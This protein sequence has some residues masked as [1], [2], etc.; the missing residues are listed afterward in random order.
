MDSIYYRVNPKKK[1][2]QF[3]NSSLAK[4]K[5]ILFYE[6]S[7]KNEKPI[8]EHILKIFKTL[9]KDSQYKSKDKIHLIHALTEEY[10]KLNNIQLE[11]YDKISLNICQ[12]ISKKEFKM[13][14]DFTSE[15]I[16]DICILI[17]LGYTKLFSSKKKFKTYEKFIS[18]IEGYRSIFIDLIK[19]Y[20]T[21]NFSV[22]SNVPEIPKNTI[23]N[24]ILLLMEILQGIK[25]INFNLVEYNKESIL[26]YIII[27]LNSDWLFPFV[28]EID[29]DLSNDN[30]SKVIERLYYQKEKNIYVKAK[31]NFCSDD[32]DEENDKELNDIKNINL[33]KKYFNIYLNKME[34][35]KENKVDNNN[36]NNN[37]DDNYSN[38][39]VND[40][41]N[42]YLNILKDNDM[43]FDIILCYFYL[44]KEIKYLKTLS[45]KMPK[46]FIKEYTDILIMK[47]IPDIDASQINI[48][49]YLTTLSSLYSF[50][51]IFNSLEKKTFENILYMI[52]NN[53]NLKELRINFFPFENN[54]NRSFSSQN[55]IKIAE[56]CD[57]ASYD[58]NAF[59][60]LTYNN[61]E[62]IKQKLL[63]LFAANLE[64]FF[65]LLQ[66]KK[67]LEKIE[68]IINLPLILYDNDGYHWSLLKF[69]FNIFSLLFK[70]NYFLKE[71]K[72]VLPFFNLDNR[73][74]PIIGEFF[75]K[76]N[77]N[78]KNKTLQ[79]FHFQ[80]S[81][82]KIYNIKNII[83]FNLLTLNI[84]E[85]DLDTFKSFV[86]FY[87][88]E[89]YLE[90]SKLKFLSITLNKTVIKYKHIKAHIIKLFT[91]KNPKN[92][93]EIN[94][95]CYFNIK[96]K[97]L[98]ELLIGTNGNHIEKYN[99]I[100]KVDNINKYK[101]I[102]E[103]NDFYFTNDE[104][105][106][107]I[108]EYLP[109]LIKYNFIDNS[110][111]QIAKKIIKSLLP[112]NRK[113]INITNIS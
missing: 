72:L 79:E 107:K 70:E 27:L 40:I 31:N 6:L 105:S 65:L 19:I 34:I 90:K 76:I 80:A 1:L 101:K 99:F 106:K 45:I 47:N 3:D 92:L 57:I 9:Y 77:L 102:I 74:F 71:F 66:T 14:L 75:D 39:V 43:I 94:F 29:L 108:S 93:F 104:I 41:E 20:K 21:Y 53:D 61:E 54:D 67:R 4:A 96:K 42:T 49:E 17:C 112:S 103:H 98:Y 37:L 109:I 91:G 10:K 48:F 50:N 25:H 89:E 30:L 51:I 84:G 88:S 68:L 22:P 110:K 36:N 8:Y 113:K 58:D 69:I 81:I 95:K 63:E 55:L 52:Q 13:N 5:S 28:F 82:S 18:E 100:M 60:N 26:P 7:T 11:K 35:I 97:K 62:I 12:K 15:N 85:L 33:I 16:N 32:S 24:E 111:K 2:L 73:K 46:G 56:E 83:S 44:I 87:K 59:I 78:E 23:P 64:K 86:D 38:S